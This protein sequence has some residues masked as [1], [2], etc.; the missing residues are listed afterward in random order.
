MKRFCVSAL[1]ALAATLFAA[2]LAQANVVVGGYYHL[3]ESD[4]GA[5]AGNPGNGTSVDSS[6]LGK[7]LTYWTGTQTYSS[8]TAATAAAATGSNLSMDFAG[9]GFYL[10]TGS[11]LTDN[12]DNFGIEGWFKV[13]DLSQQGLCNNGDAFGG[14]FGLYVLGGHVQGLYNQVALFDT[15]FTPV[16]GEWFYVAM[17]RDAGVTKMYVN[18]TTAIDFGSTYAPYV[19]TPQFSLGVAGYDYLKGSADEVR[20]IAFGSE[21]G[22]NFNASSDLLIAVPE[23]SSV[24]LF[25]T[26]M[27]GLMAYAWRKRK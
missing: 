24:M 16:L 9:D 6:G 4:A 22:Y 3:G 5:V 12:V 14:G 17:V 10:H 23:P 26:G 19:A 15:G 25:A 1:L 7:D 8:S 18:N 11:N 20:V 13:N 27:F 2:A 21:F